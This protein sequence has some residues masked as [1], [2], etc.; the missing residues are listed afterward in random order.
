MI[1]FQE[2]LIIEYQYCNVIRALKKEID[3]HMF[4]YLIQNL[5]LYNGVKI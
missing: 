5:K 1:K 3:S 2:G 4:E